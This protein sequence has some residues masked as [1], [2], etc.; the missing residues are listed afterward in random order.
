MTTILKNHYNIFKHQETL[1]RYSSNLLRHP[2][3]YRNPKNLW[4]FL[5][6]SS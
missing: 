6:S 5:K 3:N 4:N 2:K 1:V